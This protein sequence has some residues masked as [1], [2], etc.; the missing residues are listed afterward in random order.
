MFGDK[1]R[2]QLT[3]ESD[4]LIKYMMQRTG[5]LAR[6][7]FIDL[8]GSVIW[9]PVWWYTTGLKNM[10]A[11]C[12]EGLSYRA[13]QY[14]IGIWVKNF[15]VPMFAQNDWTGRLVSIWMRFVIIVLRS[16]GLVVEGLV[17]VFMVICWCVI[18]PLALALALQNILSGTFSSQVPLPR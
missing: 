6:L 14:A 17:Y 18:P 8:F 1:K 10:I 12:V 13:R 15:F 11:W 5:A 16:I 9:F 3:M 2:F 7:V 4:I